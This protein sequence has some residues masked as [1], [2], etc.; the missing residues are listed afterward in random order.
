MRVSACLPHGSI[1]VPSRRRHPVP[2]RLA[3]FSRKGPSAVASS[4]VARPA[5]PLQLGVG[6]S[7]SVSLVLT[8]GQPVLTLQEGGRSSH[9]RP[10]RG[11]RAGPAPAACPCTLAPGC[12]W[13]H[14]ELTGLWWEPGVKCSRSGR[15]GGVALV[16]GRVLRGGVD[17]HPATQ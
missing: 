3:S 13:P 17:P 8:P 9:P 1:S 15:A 6:A 14:R 11:Q 7:T 2:M 12:P 10:S 16:P 4:P 5:P